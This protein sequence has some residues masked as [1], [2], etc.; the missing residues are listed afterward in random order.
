M[1]EAVE[2]R[3]ARGR[4]LKLRA[5]VGERPDGTPI[6][7]R[8]RI[9]ETLETGDYVETAA[10]RVGISRG[11]LHGWLRDGAR[12]LQA[13]E[14]GATRGSFT[15]TQLYLAEFAVDAERAR[16]EAQLYDLGAHAMVARG[17]SKRVVRKYVP[18]R[19]A[20]GAVVLGEDGQPRMELAEM[21]EETLPPNAKALEWRLERRSPGQFGPMARIE[22]SGVD[23]RPIEHTVSLDVRARELG[24]SLAQF[25]GIGPAVDDD[26]VDADLVEG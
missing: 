13:L 10:A 12:V 19:N 22:H 9:I 6:T 23:G 18:Q 15:R 21:V 24:D 14:A 20:S 25:L 2:S 3:R 1:P 17:Q 4:P 7:M 16:A 5:K 8:E 11:T 26:V